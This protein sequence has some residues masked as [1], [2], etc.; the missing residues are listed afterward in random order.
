MQEATC[1]QGRAQRGACREA[2]PQPACPSGYVSA[3]VAPGTLKH[4]N[5]KSEVAAG[6]P[7]SSPRKG[8]L[9]A[10]HPG[11]AGGEKKGGFGKEQSSFCS[12]EKQSCPAALPSSAP[13]PAPG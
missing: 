12:K 7:S 2:N 1:P 3:G 13:A 11:M 10:S 4:Q 6:C 5:P 9:L 8:L